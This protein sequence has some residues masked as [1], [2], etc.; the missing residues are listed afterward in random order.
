M[1]FY[2]LKNGVM[3]DE[4]RIVLHLLFALYFTGQLPRGF[5]EGMKIFGWCIVRKY[6][7]L[8]YHPGS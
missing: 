7:G 1:F 6:H 4:E 2:S 3:S 5:D 8:G